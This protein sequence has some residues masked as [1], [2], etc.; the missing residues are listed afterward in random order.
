MCQHVHDYTVIFFNSVFS[1]PADS[2]GVNIQIPT[3]D[4]T[5]FYLRFKESPAV[6]PDLSVLSTVG[7]DAHGHCPC[8][9]QV[10]S[11]C[12]ILI[13]GSVPY[14]DVHCRLRKRGKPFKWGWEEPSTME[15]HLPKAGKKVLFNKYGFTYFLW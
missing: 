14:S 5:I 11:D 3:S 6:V 7:R 8:I 10:P 9:S 1:M 4:K 13:L 15:K 12:Q 2:I